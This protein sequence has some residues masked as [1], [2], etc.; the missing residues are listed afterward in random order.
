M[1]AHP[2]WSLARRQHGLVTG[3]Q[4]RAAGFTRSA[5]AHR[6]RTGRLWRAYPDVFAV[7]RA[8]VP[9]E[10]RWLAAVVWR[11]TTRF[12]EGAGTFSVLGS[13]E[14]TVA[15]W[16]ATTGARRADPPAANLRLSDDLPLRF[17]PDGRF[18]IAVG[19]K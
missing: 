11:D 8:D 4:L 3:A 7:G 18:L 12:P 14:T 10:G 5:I 15:L 1:T 19:R 6:V 9:Q 16:D 13:S 17:T 2:I